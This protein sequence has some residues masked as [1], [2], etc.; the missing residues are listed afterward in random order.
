[1]SKTKF[2]RE[3]A[4]AVARELVA[5]LRP[6]CEP[7]RLIVAG[8]LRRR[9]KEVGDV[10]ILYVPKM[11]PV[12]DGLFDIKHEPATDI[13]MVRWLGTGVLAMRENVNGSAIWGLKNKLARHAASGIP[14]DFFAT[15][16]AAWFNYLVCRTGGMESNIRIAS[17]AKDKGW[18]WNPYGAGFT[19]HR[20]E[21][22]PVKS[23]RD[24]FE[25][26]GLEYLE[27]WER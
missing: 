23:E 7:E 14:V 1:M 9:K 2:P 11:L 12:M 19:D 4:L 8:S 22:V 27:P 15:T 5:G 17:A 25:L 10:E 21:I 20:G 18:Q 24:V 3:A 16:E 6:H 26:V 13:P